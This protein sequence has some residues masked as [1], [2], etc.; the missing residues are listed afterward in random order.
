[1][2]KITGILAL[3]SLSARPLLLRN[4]ASKML[5]PY[6]SEVLEPSKPTK[7]L[8]VILLCTRAIKWIRIPM[9]TPSR[10]WMRTSIK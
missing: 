8:K 9:N 2:K 7:K 3:T 4:R 5:G 6:H 10:S 1:M